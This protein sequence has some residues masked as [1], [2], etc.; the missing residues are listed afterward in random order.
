MQRNWG[1]PREQQRVWK[2]LVPEGR[3]GDAVSARHV[4]PFASTGAWGP[5]AVSVGETGAGT[6]CTVFV[7]FL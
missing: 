4:L 3:G 6:L 7:N 5:W 2:E 1:K